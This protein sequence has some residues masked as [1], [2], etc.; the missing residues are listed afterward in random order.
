[1]WDDW[2]ILFGFNKSID[3]ATEIK[4]SITY[5]SYFWCTVPRVKVRV[6]SN[7]RKNR[8]PS[9]LLSQSRHQYPSTTSATNIDVA[10]IWDEVAIYLSFYNL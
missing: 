2:F 5:V 10:D 1:M 8:S 6:R 3:N 4:K 9:L 7:P